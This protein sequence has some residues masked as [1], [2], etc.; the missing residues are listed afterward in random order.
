[1]PSV[2]RV[3]D[4][5]LAVDPG[6]WSFAAHNA[7]AI[8]QHWERRLASNP[9]MFNGGVFVLSQ[10]DLIDGVFRGR[11]LQTDFKSYLFWRDSQFPDVGVSDAFGSA[12]IRSADGAV[13]LGRQRDG[14][15]NAG[16]AYLP[17]GFID[18]SDVGADG[19]VD[20]ETSI[21]RELREETGLDETM[22]SPEPGYWITFHGPLISC[23]QTYASR[24]S[25]QQVR[26][27]IKAHIVRE[28]D[29]E[30]VDAVIV[31]RTTDLEGQ[32]IADYA[33]TLIDWLFGTCPNA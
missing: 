11:L 30:L 27:A 7:A 1:M 8:D 19:T 14:H 28:S 29:A 12:L 22:V 18:P 16:L 4:C 3:S 5:T 10:Y 25:A 9:K 32:N 31:R 2:V 23:A 24:L 17:G 6:G 20:L 13:L 21:A 26:S 33:R 15:V